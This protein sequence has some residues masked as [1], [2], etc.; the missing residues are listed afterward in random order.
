MFSI[1][2]PAT[3]QGKEALE[4]NLKCIRGAA[5][6]LRGF[7]YHQLLFYQNNPEWASV[8][9]LILK[10]PDLGTSLVFFVILFV[11]W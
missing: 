9:M 4:F 3:Q 7:I 5:N 10:Q 11:L 8:V 6:K 1:P 2:G